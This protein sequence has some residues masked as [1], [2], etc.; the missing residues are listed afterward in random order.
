VRASVGAQNG[1]NLGFALASQEVE[2]WPENW[3]SWRLFCEIETQWRTG[4]N[5]PTGLD[6]GPL[7]ARLDRLGLTPDEWEI[8]FADIRHI[9]AAALTQMREGNDNP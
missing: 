1:F 8:R 6:Y 9:E 4:M 3:P 5:G 2:V 7:F